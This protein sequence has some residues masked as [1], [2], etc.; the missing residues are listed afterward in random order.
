MKQEPEDSDN[1][2]MMVSRAK[3]AP[4]IRCHFCDEK[5]HYKSDCPE[6]KAWEKSKKLGKETA[7]A[8][9]DS[10]DESF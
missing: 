2:A 9:W 4:E 7:A 8:A 5:G 6:R 10:D 3:P 1:M